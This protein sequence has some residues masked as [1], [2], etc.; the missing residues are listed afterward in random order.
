MQ[1]RP[2]TWP[3]GEPWLKSFTRSAGTGAGNAAVSASRQAAIV[4]IFPQISIVPGWIGGM[5]A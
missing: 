4:V 1:S 2:F 5:S 3:G